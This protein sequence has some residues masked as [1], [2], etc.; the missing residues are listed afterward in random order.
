MAVI[1]SRTPGDKPGP[2]IVDSIL[3]SDLAQ[4]ERGRAEINL[5]SVDRILES[6]TLIGTSFIRPGSLVQI[7]SSRE[8]FKSKVTT[9][10]FT[11][12]N[13]GNYDAFSSI[14]SER[15]K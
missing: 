12:T 4:R 15:I 10:A 11:V 7:T 5:H 1:V 6:G 2:D 3:S 14:E 9:F 8:V 13:E